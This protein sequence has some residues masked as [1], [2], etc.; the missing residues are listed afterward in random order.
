MEDEKDRVAEKIAPAQRPVGL[1]VHRE[2]QSKQSREPDRGGE[3]IYQQGLLEE[4]GKRSQH[5]V[6]AFGADGPHELNER[7][8]VLDVPEHVGKEDEE[9]GDSAEPD[10]LIEEDAPLLGQQQADDDT[11]AEDSNG[12]FLF[13]AKTR[14]Q[15]KPEPVA[16]LI[17][18]D[19]EEGE[20]G[21]AHP[22]VGFETI[23]TEQTAVR[24]ILGC[25]KRADSAE[26]EGV[27]AP[28]EL[29]GDG[30][31]LHDQQGRRQSGDEADAAQR[32]AKHGAA[33][34]GQERDERGLVD[35]SPGKVITTG[36]VIE[37]V[38][39]VSVAIVEVDMKQHIC[40]GNGPDDRHAVGEDRLVIAV[41]STLCGGCA[42]HTG[43]LR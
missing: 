42:D 37:L 9:G 12:V 14:N 16:W 6:A 39:K 40:Q 33:D 29:A 25:D 5:H 19:G 4:V 20:V 23:R 15:A 17:A 21:A 11:Q 13:Q 28:A 3:G 24:K 41:G 10:P 2:Q 30:G 36:H 18:L 43:C 7:P 38:A 27:A 26:E 34:V 22:E 31:G 32:V 1:E 35:V 8:V